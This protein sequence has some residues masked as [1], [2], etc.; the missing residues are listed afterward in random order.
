[1]ILNKQTS[2]GLQLLIALRDLEKGRILSLKAF[3]RQSGISFLFLQKIAKNS[4]KRV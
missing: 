1:M 3:S 4:K 2:Y